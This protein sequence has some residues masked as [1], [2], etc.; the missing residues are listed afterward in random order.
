MSKVDEYHQEL[1]EFL[2]YDDFTMSDRLKRLPAVKQSFIFRLISAKRDK[3]KLLGDKKRIKDALIEDRISKGVVT[4]SKTTLDS[5]ENDDKL[6]TF[7]EKLKEIEFLV[8]Y[9][10]RTVSMLSFVGNDM[11]NKLDHMK[12]EFE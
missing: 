10:E 2:K 4:L 8:E 3:F 1:M 6:E 5:I 11:K 7:N 9:L 12:L